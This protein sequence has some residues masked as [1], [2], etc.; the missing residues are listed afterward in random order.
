MPYKP[1]FP[2]IDAF[3]GLVIHSHDFR[4]AKAYAGLRLLCIGSSYSAEDVSIQ[5]LKF[6][7]KQIICTWRSKPMNYEFPKG[8]EE[9][10]L[11]ER[12]EKKT[13]YFKDG[14][15]AEVDVVIFCTGYKYNHPYLE[16]EFQPKETI[17]LYPDH[18]YK[19]IVWTK[20]GNNKFLFVG[21]QN[22]FFTFPM[23][24]NQALWIRK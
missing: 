11:V 20:G 21:A 16:D 15:S 4:E 1:E 14:S 8:I 7:A 2:G 6:G 10:P 3:E 18:L 17:S 5:C 23:F 22:Q 19:G 13:A 9:R 12:F 24:D